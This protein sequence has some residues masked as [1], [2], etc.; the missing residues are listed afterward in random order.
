[1]KNEDMNRAEETTLTSF[2]P[3]EERTEGDEEIWATDKHALLQCF[4]VSSTV[5][6]K[7]WAYFFSSF[8][9]FILHVKGMNAV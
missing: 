2:W 4:S 3:V 8:H 5:P 6:K 1:M 7:V 9:A